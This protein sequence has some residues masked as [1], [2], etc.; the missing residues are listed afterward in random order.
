MENHT[1]ILREK[2]Y[3]WFPLWTFLTRNEEGRYHRIA[4]DT[5]NHGSAR[6]SPARNR[7]EP[8]DG[9]ATGCGRMTKSGTMGYGRG[10][11]DNWSIDNRVG[12]ASAVGAPTAERTG[13][14]LE[15]TWKT[16]SR[17]NYRIPVYQYFQR[18]LKPIPIRTSDTELLFFPIVPIAVIV[19]RVNAELKL[20]LLDPFIVIIA[21]AIYIFPM[22]YIQSYRIPN[23]S[24]PNRLHSSG[25]RRISGYTD[26]LQSV[27]IPL[28]I[29]LLL[30]CPTVSL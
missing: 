3:K 17:S 14:N 2:S 18:R 16:L 4:G 27:S 20:A 26:Y 7:V 30:L 21:T 24:W 1:R 8:G 11:I 5:G 15:L 12:V 13:G 6:T 19:R 23:Y 25:F 22:H 10:P 29:S 9:G 28:P